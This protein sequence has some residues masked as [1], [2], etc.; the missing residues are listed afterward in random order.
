MIGAEWPLHGITNLSIMGVNE[1]KNLKE[2]TIW[3]V[4][5]I[6]SIQDVGLKIS[7]LM[8]EKIDEWLQHIEIPKTGKEFET[9]VLTT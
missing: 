7:L 3:S 1:E 2:E 5:S 8:D 4:V 6:S 9:I